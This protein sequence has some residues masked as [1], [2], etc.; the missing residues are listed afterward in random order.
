[1][2]MKDRYNHIVTFMIYGGD[3]LLCYYEINISE[4][5]STILTIDE[6]EK[7]REIA[8]CDSKQKYLQSE[9]I[10]AIFLSHMVTKE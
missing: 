3:E 6:L 2:S 1:M 10:G 5:D 8:V 7:A 4:Q 9:D